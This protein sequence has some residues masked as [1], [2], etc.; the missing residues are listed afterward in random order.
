[1]NAFITG[2]SGFVGKSLIKRMADE[3]HTIRALAL[4]SDDAGILA[5]LGAEVTSGDVNQL[6]ILEKSIRG[7][8]VVIHLAA[9]MKLM[10]DYKALYRVNV[11]G[12]R[13]MIR[14]AQ[15]AGIRR[16][17][18]VSAG[19]VLTGGPPVI[20]ADE[21]WKIPENPVGAYARTKALG[22]KIVLD[23]NSHDFSTVIV[24]PP[25]IWGA[26]D[27]AMLPEIMKAVRQGQWVWVN[28]GDYP[29]STCHVRNVCEGILLA[30]GKGHGGEVYF[31]TDGP[32]AIF[33]DFFSELIRTQGMEPGDRSVPR[34]MVRLL[35]P[36]VE[37]IWKIFYYEG[38]APLS[39]EM[40]AL[41]LSP[42]SIVDGKARSGL[43]YRGAYTRQQGMAELRQDA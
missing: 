9:I 13:N 34:W 10:G 18:H 6:H 29:Y 42:I 33:R 22:E 24:R 5:G 31:I 25:C 8:D 28:R 17:V 38:T 20:N 16:F 14:A 30:C 12:T 2:G 3:G 1:M 36:L 21:S 7:C 19:A 39:R 40:L 4:S 26:G 15:A 11:E 37:T 23:S 43:G 35:A 27:R 32:P 41:F